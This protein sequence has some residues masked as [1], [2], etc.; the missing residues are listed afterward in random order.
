M[1]FGC[2]TLI[3]WVNESVYKAV[4]L[5]FA[6]DGD[7]EPTDR[8]ISAAGWMDRNALPKKFPEYL[9]TQYESRYG[10]PGRCRLWVADHFGDVSVKPWPKTPLARWLSNEDYGGIVIAVSEYVTLMNLN[11]PG[12]FTDLELERI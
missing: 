11:Y 6:L 1:K 5:A 9:R 12:V 8:V 4:G 7:D 3:W 2:D 10:R